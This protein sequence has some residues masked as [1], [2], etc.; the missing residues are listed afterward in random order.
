MQPSLDIKSQEIH[1]PSFVA[2]R[3]KDGIIKTIP[4][5]PRDII[6][7]IEKLKKSSEY[8]L[9]R[10]IFA[11][12]PIFH[13]L[14]WKFLYDY[15][16]TVNIYDGVVPKNVLIL[17]NSTGEK[18][19]VISRSSILPAM[20]DG[21]ATAYL[22][23]LTDNSY[24]LLGSIQPCTRYE[25][26]NSRKSGWR[27]SIFLQAQIEIVAQIGKTINQ[28]DIEEKLLSNIV[29]IYRQMKIPLSNLQIRLNN[30]N[31]GVTI[32]TGIDQ[33]KRNNLLDHLNEI[34]SQMQYRNFKK[35]AKYREAAIK[36][37]DQHKSN[38]SHLQY[39]L[40]YDLIKHGV[41]NIKTLKKI[42]PE[43]NVFLLKLSQIQNRV[44]KVFPS[45]NCI[46]DPLS[47]RLGYSGLTMQVDAVFREVTFP[48]IG[49]GGFYTMKARKSWER[50]CGNPAPAGFS[51]GGFAIGLKR[52][53]RVK[54]YMKLK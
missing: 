37:L 10:K 9:A 1:I 4:L 39:Q 26:F 18:L 48:E 41:Y 8:F 11:L 36:L 44:H 34:T 43:V 19:R 3:T 46:I 32:L 50:Q 23:N 21:V 5:K 27:E 20:I 15:K 52:V 33:E 17:K 22:A 25:D 49:G 13:I 6:K 42:F 14:K 47:F 54:E 29:E 24:I 7:S 28:I 53:Q 12:V 40:L 38:F 30:F 16:E 45:I 35:S 51:M 31:I 2:V